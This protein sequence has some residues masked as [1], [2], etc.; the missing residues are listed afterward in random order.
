MYLV[1]RLCGKRNTY[2]DMR[3]MCGL[4]KILQWNEKDISYMRIDIAKVHI[5][6]I[7][8]IYKYEP[9]KN[10]QNR[11]RVQ[12]L[13]YVTHSRQE[14]SCIKMFIRSIRVFVWAFQIQKIYLGFIFGNH[15][16]KCLYKGQSPYKS[17]DN[18]NS[19]SLMSIIYK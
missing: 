3:L 19:K 4:V 9:P 12:R 15:T 2:M 17:R 16:P 8:N 1:F 18:F 14:L 7:Q 13:L 10:F 11:Q 6:S 5:F